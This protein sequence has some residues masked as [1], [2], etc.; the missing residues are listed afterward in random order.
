M[1]IERDNLWL[2][3][4]CLHVAV[5]GDATGLDYHYKPD[6]AARRLGEITRGLQS[7][8]PHLVP[9]FDSETGAGCEEFSTRWCDCCASRLAGGRHRFAVLGPDAG[10]SDPDGAAPAPSG[11]GAFTPSGP[12]DAAP[13]PSGAPDGDV[14]RTLVVRYRGD[15]Y[16][17]RVDGDA[18]DDAIRE[19]V[20]DVVQPDRG[21]LRGARYAISPHD[22]VGAARVFLDGLRWHDDARAAIAAAGTVTS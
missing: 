3:E 9:D 15:T 20:L 11:P 8:G 16:A 18:T 13:A 19:D 21:N 6:E 7:L 2:C 14:E 4:D 12:D 17:V 22:D 1:R 5:N 10:P